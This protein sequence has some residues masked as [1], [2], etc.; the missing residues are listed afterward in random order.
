MTTPG[1]PV[2]PTHESHARNEPH[3]ASCANGADCGYVAF[4]DTEEL[5][6]LRERLATAEADAQGGR[7]YHET[8]CQE[9]EKAT[10]A[11]LADAAALREQLAEARFERDSYIAAHNEKDEALRAAE[12]LALT[13]GAATDE[14]HA[15]LVEVAD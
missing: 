8:Y 5:A 6:S 10:L 15:K 4:I 9:A 2:E 12:A 11:A 1:T 13:N 7:E 3:N 14:R